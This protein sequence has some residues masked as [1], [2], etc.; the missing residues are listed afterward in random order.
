MLARDARGRWRARP[1]HH[2]RNSCNLLRAFK[3]ER[4]VFGGDRGFPLAGSYRLSARAQ[5]SVTVSRK[6]A[7][8]ATFA[9]AERPAGETIR[10]SVP[11]RGLPRGDYTVRLVVEVGRGSGGAVLDSRRL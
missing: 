5:V 9:A 2:Q 1:A 3:L 4:P 8:S 6:A 10:F 7:P 11:A